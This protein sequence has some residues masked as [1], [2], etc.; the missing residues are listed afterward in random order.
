MTLRAL[1]DATCAWVE[2]EY[3]RTEHKELGKSPIERLSSVSDVTRPSPRSEELRAAF[4]REIKRRQRRTD[5]T[6]SIAGKRFEVPGHYRTLQEIYIR[7]SEWDL[8]NIDLVDP[9]SGKVLSP[10]Y[11]LDKA[12]NS[13]AQRRA[14]AAS[15]ELEVSNEQNQ[16]DEVAPRLKE[17]MKEY[18][19]TGLPPA[20][21]AQ[22][23]EE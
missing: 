13:S 19:A 7:Y 22:D 5:G 20:Y 16:K 18:A 10:L 21:L 8:S 14:L 11:P 2:M 4:R 17:L 9:N 6:V 23:E 3:N 12:A 1:N 15:P